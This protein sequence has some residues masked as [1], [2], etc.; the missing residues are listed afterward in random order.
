VLLTDFSLSQIYASTLFIFYLFTP[1]SCASLCGWDD[2]HGPPCPSISWDEISQTIC[3]GCPHAVILL[4][5]ASSSTWDFRHELL[6]L[7]LMHFYYWDS[8][9]FALYDLHIC[10]LSDINP[11]ASYYWE[12]VMNHKMSWILMLD[13]CNYTT[14][15]NVF[16][17][18]FF[19][20]LHFWRHFVLLP[21]FPNSSCYFSS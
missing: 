16:F 17:S 1:P 2:R 15:P 11:F 12:L 4:I 3:V 9:G 10:I 7:V 19:D 8:L 6:C 5:S 20:F 13:L 18:R 21:V 14:F